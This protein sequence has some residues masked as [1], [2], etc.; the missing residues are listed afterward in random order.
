MH[1]FSCVENSFT[2]NNI[3]QQIQETAKIMDKI[4]RNINPIHPS[5]L[6]NKIDMY[7]LKII[8]YTYK[9]YN[10]NREIN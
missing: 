9:N 5:E 6:W 3:S 8:R 4:Y 2:T 1:A 7:N 10:S